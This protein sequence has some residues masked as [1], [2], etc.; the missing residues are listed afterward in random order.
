MVRVRFAPSPTGS[1]HL[2]GALTAAINRRFADEHGGVLLL[3]IDDTDAARGVAGAEEEIL[4]DLEW[5][6]IRWDEGPV[7][8]SDRA[9]RHVEA[10]RRI[11][12]EDAEG[13]V[14]FGRATLVRETPVGDCRQRPAEMQRPRGT[15]GEADAHHGAPI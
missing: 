1:L 14:R 12:S 11:G 7:R 13:A 3:R 5:L 9:E 10:A 2:G 6:G 8:Q 15:R 4:G